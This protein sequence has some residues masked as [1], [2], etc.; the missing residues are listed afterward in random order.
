LIS[1]TRFRIAPFL[2]LALTCLA[3][4]G[5][6]PKPD[7]VLVSIDTLRADAVGVYGGPV[8]T[9]TL[10]G[11]AAQGVRFDRVFAPAP[12]TAPSHATMFTG[13]D[14]LHHGLLRNGQPLPDAAAT[15]AEAFH[16]GGWHTAGF[17]SS[18]VL[19]HRFGWA[20]GFDLWDDRIPEQGSTMRKEPY[21]GAFWSAERFAGFDRRATVT[22]QAAIEWLRDAPEPFFLFVHYF[23]PHAPY[24][25]PRPYLRRTARIDVPLDDRAVQGVSADQLERLIQRYHGEVLYTDDSLGALLAAVASRA[26]DRSTLVVVTA[27]HGEGLGQ[28]GWIEHAT[29]LYDEQIRVP[30]ILSW[31]GQL[32]AGHEVHTPVGLV[33]LAPTILDLVGLPPLPGAD[34]RSLAASARGGADPVPR[35]LFGDRHLVAE[36]TGWGH[37]VLSSVRTPAWKL[38]RSSDGTEQLFDLAADPREL[39][40]LRHERAD[41]AAGLE[42][43]L[44]EHDAEQPGAAP[45]AP[46]S[47]DTKRALRALGYL[48]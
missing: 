9:P 39:H 28:H 38:I 34:G 5:P 13:Q 32:P 18:F 10:D 33:D 48:K 36:E 40:D 7:V 30:W 27:D 31:P 45:A 26:R 3:A 4:C 43:L 12:A 6:K 2:A 1:P 35:P 15:L 29:Y 21:P 41:V 19:D 16:T 25:P 37:G 46:V 23:D 44:Q 24:A 22:T 11:L 8:P 17:V 20:Q 42:G 14:V 47:E